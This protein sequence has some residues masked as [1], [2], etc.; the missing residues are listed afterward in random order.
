MEVKLSKSYFFYKS[1]PYVFK[2]VQTLAPDGHHKIT[3]EFFLK[4]SFRF[5]TTFEYQI[6]HCTLRKEQTPQLSGKR[7]IVE[8]NEVKCETRGQ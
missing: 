4:L 5:L 3:V 2:F 8:R 6:H 7:T 1:Q